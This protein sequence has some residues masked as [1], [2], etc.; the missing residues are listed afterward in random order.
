[1]S[2]LFMLLINLIVLSNL[3]FEFADMSVEIKA[4]Q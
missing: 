1:M 3:N 4:L 2:F